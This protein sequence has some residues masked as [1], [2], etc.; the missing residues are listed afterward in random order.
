MSRE[1]LDIDRLLRV[2]VANELQRVAEAQLE[3]SWQIPTEL[4]RRA[5][6][7]RARTVQVEV[8]RGLLR[9]ADDGDGVLPRHLECLAQLLDSSR[10]PTE[11][12]QA[13]IELEASDG[14]VWIALAGL[15]PRSL[16][17]TSASGSLRLDGTAMQLTQGGASG[18]TR[19]ELRT[20]GVDAQRA[21]QWLRSA[22]RF[23]DARISLQGSPIERGFRSALCTTELA[24]PLNGSIALPDSGDTAT[25]WLL[26]HGIV[27]GHLS[28]P[29]CIPFEAALNVSTGGSLSAADA[30]EA[31]RPHLESLKEAAAWLAQSVAASDS[32]VHVRPRLRKLVLEGLI[33][34]P[35]RSTLRAARVFE[36]LVESHPKWLSLSDLG[37]AMSACV[38]FPSQ[39]P[40][41]FALGDQPVLLLTPTERGPFTEVS[42]LAL[43]APQRRNA[44]RTLMARLRLLVRRLADGARRLA[45][46]LRAGAKPVA[47]EQLRPEESQLLQQ[48][49][50]AL[51]VQPV[52][53]EGAG[54]I[55]RTGR[56]LYLPRQ[57]ALVRA[58]IERVSESPTWLYPVGMAL[59]QGRETPQPGVRARWL[60]G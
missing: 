53:C 22:C 41:R 35:G 9:I 40:E 30:R 34:E 49:E 14:A 46:R 16:T 56:R 13:L 47:P 39:K 2:D 17:I 45:G 42:G 21:G 32:A 4:V 19:I 27:L 58:A 1:H 8:R 24:E 25:V 28:L 38:L 57:N 29:E 11:R 6:A 33:R 44:S 52:F 59:L 18:G 54:R 23:A 10:P 5:L 51:R 3:G 55:R 37:G 15:H 43:V 50:T 60:R 36:A 12:H 7:S 48:L 31:A 20:S 26:S